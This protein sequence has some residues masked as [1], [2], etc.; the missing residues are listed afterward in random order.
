ML[1]HGKGKFIFQNNEIYEGN[2][3]EG[4]FEGYGRY[5]HENGTKYMG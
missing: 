2:L 5:V 1:P 4:L 3:K